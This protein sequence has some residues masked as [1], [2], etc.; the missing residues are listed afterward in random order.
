MEYRDFVCIRQIIQDYYQNLRQEIDV[1][2][3]VAQDF[4]QIDDEEQQIVTTFN[5]AFPQYQE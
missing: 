5:E 3:A 1:R 4:K 2:G